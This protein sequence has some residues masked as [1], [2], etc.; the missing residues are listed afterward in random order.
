MSSISSSKLFQ[1]TKVGELTLAHR[2]VLAPLTRDRANAEH[3]H[4]ALGLEYYTQRSSVPGS[5]LI[6]EATI[7]APQAGGHPSAPGITS[8]AQIA[9]WKKI[10]DAVHANGSFIYLQ[11]WALGRVADPKDL[12]ESDPSFEVVGPSAIPLT[13]TGVIPHELSI[14]EIKQY[15]EFYRKSALDGINLAG[16]DGVELHM[17]NGYLLDQ[18]LQDNSNSRTDE[19]GGSVENRVR[20]PLE[21]VEA[22]VQAVGQEKVAVRISPWSLFQDMRMKD[23][24]QTFA[25]FVS[26]IR[27]LYPKLAYLHV[28]QPR[29]LGDS[30]GRSAGE[31]E[32]N[33]FLREIWFPRPFISAGGFTVE[34]ATEVAD[35][36]GELIA[37][38][39]LY[40]ANPDLPSRL[41]SGLPLAKPDRSTFYLRE[42]AKGYIDYPFAQ[43]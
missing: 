27:D 13:G 31:T 18:F 29:V 9:A 4:G 11:L 38:G 1:P 33:D 17:A 10:V 7:V 40:I 42:S 3:V 28:V 22:V 15:I 20:F 23:P 36:S 26:R 43:F 25:H 37:F 34:T 2:V 19:Y 21:V 8:D 14:P 39:R 35:R 32:S 16:F 6:T 12:K 30:D 41:K 24:T 5:L